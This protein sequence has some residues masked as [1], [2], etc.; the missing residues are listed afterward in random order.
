MTSFE[1]VLIH[2]VTRYD[3]DQE[4]KSLKNKKHYYNPY[5]L[6]LMLVRVDNIIDDMKRKNK[7]VPLSDYFN[8]RLLQFVEKFIAK[9]F[10]EN[11]PLFRND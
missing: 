1:T 3:R 11:M 10:K 9:N 2:A 8:D 5:A 6:G 4:A 7:I